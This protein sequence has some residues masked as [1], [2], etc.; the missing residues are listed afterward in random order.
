M[1]N[2]DIL[3]ENNHDFSTTEYPGDKEKEFLKN[4]ITKVY[5]VLFKK[6]ELWKDALSNQEEDGDDTRKELRSEYTILKPF[7]QEH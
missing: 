2:I 5:K 7:G 1:T 4:E 3:K 6:L